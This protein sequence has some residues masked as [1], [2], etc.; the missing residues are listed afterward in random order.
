MKKPPHQ[1]RGSEPEDERTAMADDTNFE[2]DD[3]MSHPTIET[4]LDLAFERA[5]SDEDN[6][7]SLI[8]I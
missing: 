8:H 6:N 4:A 7:L 5:R 3:S 2:R 1:V